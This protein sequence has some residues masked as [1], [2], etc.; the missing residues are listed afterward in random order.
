MK[1]IDLCSTFG[2]TP[3]TKVLA[4][5]VFGHCVMLLLLLVFLLQKVISKFVKKGSDFWAKF[6][7]RLVEAFLM[8]VLF[9]LQ[10][11]LMGIFSSVQCIEI[12][13]KTVLHIH[14]DIECF[15][16]WQSVTQCYIF[17]NVIPL[18]F[19]VSCAPFCVQNRT[20]SVKV[21]VLSC[22]CPL[23]T[24]LFFT[25]KWLKN[26]KRSTDY[27]AFAVPALVHIA[28]VRFLRQRKS[29]T[30]CYSGPDGVEIPFIDADVDSEGFIVPE[31]QSPVG[32]S[33]ENLLPPSVAV[34]A[35]EGFPIDE[36]KI[37]KCF[38]IV[39]CK[40]LISWS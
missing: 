4:K 10:K 25:V 29:V 34:Q 36:I 15:T 19:V 13:G 21:F 39:Q 40:Q 14:G 9:S 6:R 31:V 8:T 22:L 3:V 24:S 5:S 32:S 1:T 30:K 37:H 38:K 11:L 23:P 7:A 28:A 18:L 16:W 17:V 26:S 27:G 33:D 12:G 20:M 35:T 2:L